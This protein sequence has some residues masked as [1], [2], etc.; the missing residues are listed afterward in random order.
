MALLALPVRSFLDTWRIANSYQK[1]DKIFH[2]ETPV[3][4]SAKL[5]LGAPTKADVAANRV[6]CCKRF[7]DSTHKH[8][9]THWWRDTFVYILYMWM[10]GMIGGSLFPTTFINL[11]QPVVCDAPSSKSTGLQHVNEAYQE[12]SAPPRLP[13]ALLMLLRCALFPSAVEEAGCFSSRNLFAAYHR[14]LLSVKG[15]RS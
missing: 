1:W 9:Q 4:L 8:T 14:C 5:T 10:I 7:S 3:F 2:G 15:S 13:Q 6:L 11:Y 12:P